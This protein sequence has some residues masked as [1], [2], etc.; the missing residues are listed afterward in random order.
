M[1]QTKK[2]KGNRRRLKPDNKVNY[3]ASFHSLRCP[4]ISSRFFFVPLIYV[5]RVGHT[6]RL[7]SCCSASYRSRQFPS[8]LVQRE[9]RLVPDCPVEGPVLQV[10]WA[11]HWKGLASAAG[12]IVRP[13]ES[14]DH[15][16][17]KFC[18]IIVRNIIVTANGML[19]VCLLLLAQ[20]YRWKPKHLI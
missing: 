7:L 18:W 20:S 11:T 17:H 14:N 2:E 19:L 13:V 8:I 9:T 12:R 15:H 16:F 5:K 10:E 4:K 6:L 1:Y 3:S